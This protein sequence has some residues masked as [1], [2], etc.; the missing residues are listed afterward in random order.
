LRKLDLSF[1]LV[2]D[3]QLSYDGSRL[4]KTGGK[5][6]LEDLIENALMTRQRISCPGSFPDDFD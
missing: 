5:G 3:A 1:P 4:E 2:K 6:E